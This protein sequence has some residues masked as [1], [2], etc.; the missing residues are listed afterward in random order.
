MEIGTTL[1]LHKQPWKIHLSV[2][3]WIQNKKLVK[4]FNQ[5]MTTREG[6]SFLVVKGRKNVDI[7]VGQKDHKNIFAADECHAFKAGKH[8]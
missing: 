6:N 3:I 2:G 4:V 5:W 1:L 7:Q 8:S